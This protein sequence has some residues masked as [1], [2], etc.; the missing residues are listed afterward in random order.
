MEGNEHV[1]LLTKLLLQTGAANPDKP[2]QWRYSLMA[3]NLLMMLMP[4]RSA[5]SA[6]TLATH[7][8]PL[9]LHQQVPQRMLASSYFIYV[10]DKG[11]HWATVSITLPSLHVWFS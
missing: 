6:R 10:L 7:F 5:E 4:V 8:M 2:V 3:N 1:Q 11:P 9:L